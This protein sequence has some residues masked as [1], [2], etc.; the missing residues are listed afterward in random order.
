MIYIDDYNSKAVTSSPP[1][2]EDKIELA[3]TKLEMNS[4]QLAAFW[5]LAGATI[6]NNFVE[7][8]VL[9]EKYGY[10]VNNEED[11][12]AA[13]TDMLGTP[14]WTKFVKEFGEII[15]ST[16]DEKIVNEL[17]EN[18]EESGW[19]EALIQAVGAVASSSLNLGASSKQLKATKEN[20]KSQMFT[21]IAATMA[22]R[23]RTK[24]EIEKTR[25]EEKKGVVWI[26]LAVILIIGII[27]GIVIYKKNKAQAAV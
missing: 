8:K 27:V 22:E 12:A 25:R 21:G 26:I 16:I 4:K 11:A 5:Y 9:L 23:E 19:V 20:A 6:A 15:E 24:A 2:K 1:K 3:K 13:I 10:Q 18:N 17:K 14:K 7:V